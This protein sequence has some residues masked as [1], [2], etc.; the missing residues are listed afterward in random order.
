[1]NVTETK[2]MEHKDKA[3]EYRKLATKIAEGSL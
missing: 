1:M 2:A 3:D